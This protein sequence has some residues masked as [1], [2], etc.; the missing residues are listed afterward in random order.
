[1]VLSQP[2][3]CSKG[4]EKEVFLESIDYYINDCIY[5]PSDDTRI[6]VEV[7]EKGEISERIIEVGSG[8]GVV[9]S[10]AC[11]ELGI[12]DLVCIDINPCPVYSTLLTLKSNCSNYVVFDVIQ[13]DL[14]TCLRNN[15]GGIVVINP[16]YL[17]KSTMRARD[18]CEKQFKASIEHDDPLRLFHKLFQEANR[19]GVKKLFLVY[20]S[21][22]IRH[23]GLKNI[24]EAHGF[25]VKQAI[26]KH[27]FF[28]DI[29]G[30]EAEYCGNENRSS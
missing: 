8:T 20:S 21:L 16:P 9:G 11:R 1:M 26:S 15:I 27:V 18:D 3:T 7:L 2:Y 19:I 10:Y 28:E 13:G 4:F 22:A 30:V 17:R 5:K 23:D 14:T 25:C 29:T 6:I 12:R 24:L